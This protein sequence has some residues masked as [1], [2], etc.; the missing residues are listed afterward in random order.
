MTMKL[1][2]IAIALIATSAA[3]FAAD[4]SASVKTRAEV[5]TEVSQARAEGNLPQQTEF[6]EFANI[7][8]TKTRAQVRAELAQEKPRSIA[9]TEYVEPPR[10][11]SG[12]SRAEVR[13]ELEPAY[14][15]GEMA[16]PEFVEYTRVASTRSRDE[17]RAEAIRAAQ[18]SRQR[19]GHSGS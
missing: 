18:E 6:I 14:A 12:K 7:P 4:E 17:V 9:R 8:S 10:V 16:P 13:A 15:P 19:A 5:R 11:A 1:P 2:S 3:A